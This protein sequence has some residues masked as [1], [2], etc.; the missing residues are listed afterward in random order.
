MPVHN[1]VEARTEMC[2]YFKVIVK[3]RVLNK[4]ALPQFS[5]LS[6]CTKKP[7]FVL[8]QACFGELNDI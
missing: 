7:R 1:C 4:P 2:F 8:F 5:K 6:L 3:L